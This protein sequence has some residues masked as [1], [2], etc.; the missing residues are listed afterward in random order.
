MQYGKKRDLASTN[1][2]GKT[3]FLVIRH[4]RNLEYDKIQ[5]GKHGPENSQNH[6]R[7]K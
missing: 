5:K 7:F 3:H 1:L 2:A 4:V 6:F